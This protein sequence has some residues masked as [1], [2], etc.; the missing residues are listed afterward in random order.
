MS[1]SLRHHGLYRPWTS[2][3]QNTGV[4]SHSL[5]QGTFPAQ[6]LNPGLCYCRRILY[7]EFFTQG[8]SPS[9]QR[10]PWVGLEA[11]VKPAG[12]SPPACVGPS[13]YLS[14][15]KPAL[16]PRKYGVGQKVRFCFSVSSFR[17]TRMN[18]LADPGCLLNAAPK[19]SGSYA[20]RELP[21]DRTAENQ[22]SIA[23]HQNQVMTSDDDGVGM[24]Q[25]HGQLRPGHL[26]SQ[27]FNPHHGLTSRYTPRYCH[28]RRQRYGETK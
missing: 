25:T 19:T 17:K 3:G 23:E 9:H 27:A 11:Q 6:G 5:L 13:S 15:L 22:I 24:A 14:C 20:G 28:T 21:C 1:D 2:L 18:F 26:P 10:S 7:Q 16:C 8:S 4:G 12:G